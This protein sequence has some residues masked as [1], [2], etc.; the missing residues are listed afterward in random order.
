M[1]ES[2]T[3]SSCVSSS[4]CA[5]SSSSSSPRSWRE[6]AR[7]EGAQ[8]L[9]PEE[10]I[11]FGEC[12]SASSTGRRHCRSPATSRPGPLPSPAPT[13]S[14]PSALPSPQP[15]PSPPPPSPLLCCFSASAAVSENC[16]R[17]ARA[18]ESN[19][20]RRWDWRGHRRHTSVRPPRRPRPPVLQLRL[21][22]GSRRNVHHSVDVLVCGTSAV[23]MTSGYHAA[24]YDV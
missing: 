17:A 3:I 6:T 4:S 20:F 18:E 10:P 16:K 5:S 12:D 1:C 21:L 2:V 24:T 22:Q 8:R 7:R 14:P 9:Q 13:S 23:L 19:T 15:S 11:Q